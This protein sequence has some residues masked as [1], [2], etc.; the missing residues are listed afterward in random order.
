MHEG[1]HMRQNTQCMEEAG[2]SCVILVPILEDR[3]GQTSVRAP[4]LQATEI[5][6]T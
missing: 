4:V 6:L 2:E 1:A 5:N 3:L